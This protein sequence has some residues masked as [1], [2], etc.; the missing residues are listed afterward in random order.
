MHP[1][2]PPGP[3]GERGRRVEGGREVGG[4][5]TEGGSRLVEGAPLLLK[6][7]RGKRESSTACSTGG[8]NRLAAGRRRRPLLF[9]S[10]LYL[11]RPPSQ[12]QPLPT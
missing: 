1:P 7:Q 12:I 10:H 9:I 3:C 6:G 4:G 8:G 5:E 11:F 2:T